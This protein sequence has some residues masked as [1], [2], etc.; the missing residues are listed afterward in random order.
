MATGVV[1]GSAVILVPASS[2]P[3]H[4]RQSGARDRRLRQA[5]AA[6]FFSI[7]RE[8]VTR[9]VRNHFNQDPV[10]HT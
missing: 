9:P 8:A 1:A 3:L 6:R 10:V 5:D 2:P 7:G 4:A